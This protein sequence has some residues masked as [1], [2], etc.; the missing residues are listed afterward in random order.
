MDAYK[1]NK[2]TFIKL[3]HSMMKGL[4]R[5]F[6]VCLKLAERFMKERSV[7]MRVKKGTSISRDVEMECTTAVT[8]MYSGNEHDA[9]LPYIE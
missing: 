3:K 5:S 8:N 2:S 1:K 4:Q 6:F 7:S 9:Q